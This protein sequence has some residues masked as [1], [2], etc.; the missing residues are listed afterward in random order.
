MICVATQTHILA[1]NKYFSLLYDSRA[2]CWRFC[3][4]MKMKFFLK[5]EG[6]NI[7]AR[8][9][10]L[11]WLITTKRRFP[12]D[13]NLCFLISDGHGNSLKTHARGK[14]NEFPSFWLIFFS[15]RL[16]FSC[17]KWFMRKISSLPCFFTGIFP[18]VIQNSDNFSI[19][20]LL[21]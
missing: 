14:T 1:K 17:Y 13:D 12:F 7:F 5:A 15:K 18:L 4:R 19:I 3:S 8:C 9:K 21:F 20:S 11:N 16:I 2:Q 6:Q 10:I